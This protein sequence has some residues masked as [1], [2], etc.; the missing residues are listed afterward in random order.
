MAF[1]FGCERGRMGAFGSDYGRG[2]S[3]KWADLGYFE[4]DGSCDGLDME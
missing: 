2:E 4:A 1:V 3:E